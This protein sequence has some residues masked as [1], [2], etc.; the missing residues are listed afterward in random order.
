M[1]RTYGYQGHLLTEA[2]LNEAKIRMSKLRQSIRDNLD[3]I[4]DDVVGEGPNPAGYPRAVLAEYI[5]ET[6]DAIDIKK[7]PDMNEGLDDNNLVS[8]LTAVKE[9]EAVETG[10]VIPNRYMD[11]SQSSEELFEEYL[12]GKAEYERFVSQDMITQ[13]Y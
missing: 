2:K 13:P 5:M 1:K 7:Y 3:E 4:I 12:K 9:Y 10:L 8:F 11:D 6:Y